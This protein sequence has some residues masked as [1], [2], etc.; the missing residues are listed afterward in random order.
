[1]QTRHIAT[2]RPKRAAHTACTVLLAT[3]AALVMLFAIPQAGAAFKF[4]SKGSEMPEIS[5]TAMDGQSITT[6]SLKEG[7]AAI[8]VFWATWSPRSLEELKALEKIWTAHKDKGLQVV[9]VN[10]NHL[11]FS[12]EDIKKVEEAVAAAGVTFP[13]ALDKG[14]EVYNTVGVVATP[15]TLVMTAAGQVTYEVSS[16]LSR[17]GEQIQEES[18]IALGIRQ[19]ATA[20]AQVEEKNVYKPV[21]KA[22]LYYNLGRNLLKM[23]SKEKA[24]DK[25]TQAAAEDPKYAAPR[26]ILGHLLLESAAKDPTRLEEAVK[27]F[28][29]AVA[30][31]PANV[32]ALS[33]LGE[34]L[35]RTGKLEEAEARFGEALKIDGTYTPSITGLATILSKK[36]SYDQARSKF[37]E[38]LELNPLNPDVYY[39]RAASFEAQGLLKEAAGDLRRAVEILLGHGTGGGEV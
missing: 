2:A 16:F 36:G 28:G 33:G 39:R 19:P 3:V 5:L 15:S 12:M 25:F 32:S 21:K 6:A 13:I 23:G 8:V 34:G 35:L 4:V 11:T 20:T 26:V 14:L 24:I 30:A 1:M 29:E 17:T 9:G 18:E 7:K 37:K 22:M 27:L 10:V 38:A 31:D